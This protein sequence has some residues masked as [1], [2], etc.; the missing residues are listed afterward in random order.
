MQIIH[1]YGAN[2]EIKFHTWLLFSYFLRAADLSIHLVFKKKK[3]ITL[4]KDLHLQNQCIFSYYTNLFRV[5]IFTTWQ[6]SKVWMQFFVL[7]QSYSVNKMGFFSFL[8]FAEIW[9]Q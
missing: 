2:T 9:K 7:L 6:K 3:H 8:R 1:H 5:E 4:L